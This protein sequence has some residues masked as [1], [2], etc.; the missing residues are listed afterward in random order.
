MGI[1]VEN[2][3]YGGKIMKALVFGS[4]NIDYVYYVDHIVMPGETLSSNEMKAFCGGKGLNQSI[5]LAKAGMNTFIAGK[6]GNDGMML[7]DKCKEYSV[8]TEFVEVCD[9]KSGNTI[10]QVDKNG[11]NSILLFSGT[12][13]MQQR[14]YINKVLNYFS[15]NDLLFLQNEINE[16]PYIIDEGHR[17]GMTIVLNPSPYNET[18]LD[19]DLKKVDWLILNEIEGKQMT[20]KE[21]VENMLKEICN[22]YPHIKVVLTLGENGAIYCDSKRRYMQKSYKMQVVDTTAA[23]D[24]FTGFFFAKILFN[25][26]EVALDMA[27]KAAAISISRSGAAE[28]IPNTSEVDNIVYS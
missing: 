8:E 19:C 23:G 7:L 24:T 9:N 2:I 11:Q 15:E 10:I 18:L 13:K 14:E 4:L 25:D 26:I 21:D 5:A 28:S 6:I 22:K 1:L 27:A 20:G 17:K 3:K 12:N 16:L